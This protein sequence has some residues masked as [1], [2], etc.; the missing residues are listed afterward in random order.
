V[1]FPLSFR[2]IVPGRETLP[3]GYEVPRHRH[4]E[5]YALVL[6]AG[7]FEQTSYAGR[8]TVAPGDL[9]VQPTLDCHANRLLSDGAQVLRLP[10]PHVEGSGGMYRLR[11]LDAIV[12]TAARDVRAAAELARADIA[13]AAP[14]PAPASDWPDLLASDICGGRVSRLS[15]WA[16]AK[17]LAVETLSRGFA[18]LYGVPP[19]RFR[20]EWR[21]RAAWMRIIGTTDT[22]AAIAAATG[23][24]DQAHMT[25]SVVELT[26]APPSDWRRRC[27]PSWPAPEM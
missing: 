2:T 14:A 9:L 6:I 1:K 8:V 21:A 22:F 4:L 13:T 20:G 12:R 27:R 18:R 11:D 15:E 17:G 3:R 24:S 19:A 10:W 25:R 16:L 5:P 7:A 26:G 23:F